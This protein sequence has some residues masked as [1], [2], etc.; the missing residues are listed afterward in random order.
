MLTPTE[1]YALSGGFYG[2]VCSLSA[3]LLKS[4]TEA[5][6][7]PQGNTPSI[8]GL[9]LDLCGSASQVQAAQQLLS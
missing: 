9:R 2:C 6:G 7:W 3:E 1:L 4:V 8:S 5:S